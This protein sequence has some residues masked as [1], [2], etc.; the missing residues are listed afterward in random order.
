VAKFYSIKASAQ[1]KVDD[2]GQN[3]TERSKLKQFKLYK[4]WGIRL[5]FRTIFKQ[6][7]YFLTT[8]ASSDF[9]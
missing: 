5:E 1:R 8:I 9:G 2:H 4:A 6:G 7:G 3:I